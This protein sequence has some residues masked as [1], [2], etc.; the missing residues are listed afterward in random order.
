MTTVTE[1]VAEMK[2]QGRSDGPWVFRLVVTVINDGETDYRLSLRELKAD[3][4]T[5]FGEIYTVEAPAGDS[6]R[7][8]ASWPVGK[9]ARPQSLTAEAELQVSVDSTRPAGRRRVT[10][11]HVPVQ[12]ER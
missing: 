1:R 9:T 10:F 8:V 11:G 3:D 5:V 4:G 6:T 12:M 7:L 2:I